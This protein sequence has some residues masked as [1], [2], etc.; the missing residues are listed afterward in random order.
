MIGVS[1]HNLGKTYSNGKVAVRNLNL[2][3]YEDQITSFLG[4][5]GAGKTTTMCVNNEFFLSI[6]M[7][8]FDSNNNNVAA[9]F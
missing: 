1:I 8:H 3:F 9:L 6:L 7:Q 2:D 5:N 4:H